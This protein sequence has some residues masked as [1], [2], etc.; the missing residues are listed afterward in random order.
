MLQRRI[1]GE[2]VAYIIEEWEFYGLSFYVNKHVLVPRP[3]T[4]MLVDLL[5]PY[6]GISTT[7]VDVGTGSGCIPVAISNKQKVKRVIG[8][9]ISAEALKVAQKNAQRHDVSAEFVEGDLFEPIMNVFAR[10]RKNDDDEAIQ[11]KKDKESLDCHVIPRNDEKLVIAANLPYVPESEKHPSVAKEPA[12]AI[13]SGK[14]GLDL[15]RQFFDQLSNIDF[16]VCGFEFH[17]PQKEILNNICIQKF[18]EHSV[19]F[20]KDLSGLWRIGMLVKERKSE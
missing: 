20:H 5:L 16:D 1:Q 17:P 3:E 15:F 18:P 2:P 13:Y 8:I 11:T 4:E 19:K 10:R 14:D 9:D 12:S 6:V 7:F